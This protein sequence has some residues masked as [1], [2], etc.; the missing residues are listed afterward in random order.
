MTDENGI[1]ISIETV[2]I[3]FLAVEL[4]ETAVPEVSAAQEKLA[5]VDGVE[6]PDAVFE[7]KL[8]DAGLTYHGVRDIE[9]RSFLPKG[10]GDIQQCTL[11]R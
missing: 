7:M 10:C 11:Q 1:K 9:W 6:N 4:T 3:R 2:P 5:C 8:P